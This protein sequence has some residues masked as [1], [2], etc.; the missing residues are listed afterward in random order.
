MTETMEKTEKLDMLARFLAYQSVDGSSDT[1]FGVIT[2]TVLETLGYIPGTFAD[3][4]DIGRLM[5]RFLLEYLIQMEA[6]RG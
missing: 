3:T 6:A 1:T 5:R 4:T 2:E